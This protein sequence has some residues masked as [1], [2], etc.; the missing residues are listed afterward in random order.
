MD[1]GENLPRRA[2]DPVAQLARQDLDPMSVAELDQR[3][4]DLEAEIERV[5]RHRDRAV[6]HR[7]SADALF[8]R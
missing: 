7:A 5:R 1:S 8:K 3:V 2:D 6:N 4:A